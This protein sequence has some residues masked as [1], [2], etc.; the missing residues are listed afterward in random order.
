MPSPPFSNLPAK[1]TGSA[2]QREYVWETLRILWPESA[3][4]SRGHRAVEGRDGRTE[5]IVVPSER[6]PKLLLP[7]RPRRAAA[8]ALRHYKASA[9]APQRLAFHG[10]ALTVQSGLADILPG[11]ISIEAGQGAA[12]EDIARYL[13]GVLDQQAII[14]LRVGPPRANRKPVLELLTADGGLIGFAKVGVNSLT[15]ELVRAEAAALALL[16]PAQLTRL[17]VP[18]LIHHGQW[19][20]HEVLVQGALSGAAPPTKW[21]GLS[22]A[23]AELAGIKGV[24]WLSADHSPYWRDLWQ[25]LTACAERDVAD[26]LLRALGYLQP[27]AATSIAF[28]CWHGDWTPWNMAVS[29]GRA[30][31]WDWERFQAGIPIGYDALHYWLQARVNTGSVPQAVAED[32]VAE[33]PAVLA[34]FRVP[35][36]T[37]RLI[38]TL[39]LFEIA[40]RY[41]EDRQAE[42]GAML[43]DVGTWLLPALLRHAQEVGST[44]PP[45]SK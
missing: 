27:A 10:L 8:A 20:G 18:R 25:R 19:H 32:A 14:S 2:D 7:R 30:L 11:R 16:G 33:A 37:A 21:A 41:V 29:G 31:V 34:P 35:P 6:R 26:V 13:A 12:D 3:C 36:D 5:F 4:I 9:T 40:V 15:C 24:T 28:G 44:G 1:S 45:G 23:M 17:D 39:Y 38:A 43:G 22:G 42:A